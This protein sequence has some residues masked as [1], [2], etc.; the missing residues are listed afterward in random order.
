MDGHAAARLAHKPEP[1][2]SGT[3]HAT[4]ADCVYISFGAAQFTS[5]AAG[6]AGTPE[7]HHRLDHD[8]RHHHHSDLEGALHPVPGLGERA[9]LPMLL[10][11]AA[12]VGA[13][14]VCCRCHRDGGRLAQPQDVLCRPGT[15]AAAGCRTPIATRRGARRR[16]RRAAA[17]AT[18]RPARHRRGALRS[19]RRFYC[20]IEKPPPE[21]SWRCRCA[22]GPCAAPATVA[23]STAEEIPTGAGDSNS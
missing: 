6:E 15:A 9:L 8:L 7:A 21:P 14:D 20:G 16:A 5:P 4:N 19:V 12:A 22:P 1:D 10:F 18:R 3:V 17:A 11:A 2:K 23:I 13:G